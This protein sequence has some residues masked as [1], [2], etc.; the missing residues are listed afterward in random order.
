M[1]GAVKLRRLACA[2]LAT[3]PAWGLLLGGLGHD[4]ASAAGAAESGL[5]LDDLLQIA[6]P[7]LWDRPV[8]VPPADQR[9]GSRRGRAPRPA[10]SSLL[11]SSTALERGA[12]AG[13]GVGA[14]GASQG[15]G[16][17]YQPAEAFQPAAGFQAMAAA[18]VETSHELP[19]GV[20]SPRTGDNVAVNEYSAMP[21]VDV[22]KWVE[23][24]LEQGDTLTSF[25]SAKQ[26]VKLLTQV[27]M[28]VTNGFYLD[29]NA[30]DGETSSNTLLLELLGW[31]G[32][33]VEPRT[34]W[35]MELW[36]KFRKAWLFLGALS[37]HENATKL[38]FNYDGEVDELSGHQVHAYPLKTFLQEM[39]GRKTI[40]F[41]NLRSGGYEAEI[42]NETLFHSGSFIEFGVILVTFDGRRSA[43][44]S[45]DYVQARS[46]DEAEGLIFDLLHNAS[47][48]Y[49]GGL[50]PYWINTV[51]PRYG[52]KDAVF[53]NPTYFV[54]RN[55][56]LPTSVKGPPPPTLPGFSPSHPWAG[57]SSWEEGFTHSEEVSLI[58]KYIKASKQDASLIEPVPKANRVSSTLTIS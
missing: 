52:F 34:Y 7:S 47:F 31:R 36:S 53:V 27:L 25:S 16:P 39:G 3:P 9:S 44:G 10:A 45:Q 4:A 49:I 43:R 24:S 58:G 19:W 56:A 51:E 28:N 21:S 14:G 17:Q 54:A 12:G 32:L 48:K 5:D 55:I 57:F 20:G 26:D 11:E 46:R 23:Y 41:W 42:L 38:G 40:D 30:M 13:A 33:C 37:P 50:D 6:P 8:L 1:A 29:T 35:Y 18:A 15:L 2:L 22:P